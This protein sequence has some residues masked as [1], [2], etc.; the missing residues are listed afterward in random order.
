MLARS[1]K[2][3]GGRYDDHLVD[4][5]TGVVKAI[6]FCLLLIMYWAINSQLTNTF[7][8]QAERMD[9]RLG[10]VNIP[11]A[12]LNAFNTIGIIVLIPLVDKV[13]YPFFE[14]VRYPLT[15]LKRIGPGGPDVHGV[16]HVRV[17]AGPPVLPHRNQRDLRQRHGAENKKHPM[18]KE[19]IQAPCLSP[20]LEFAYHQA[21]VAMQGLLTGLFLASPGI[22]TWGAVGILAVV[23]RATRH[24]PWFSIEIN[25]SKMENLMFLLAGLMLLNLLVF[26]VVAHLYSYQD[27]RQFQLDV[28]PRGKPQG[29]LRTLGGT[30][31]RL[32][33]DYHTLGARKDVEDS[34]CLAVLKEGER[35]PLT[36]SGY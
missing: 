31:D 18:N 17:H 23:R 7:F 34:K 30:Y 20:A 21:P 14:R 32:D 15:F 1:K 22:G 33:G 12:A 27:P 25:E 4:G 19:Y 29:E 10:S 35:T 3:F 36:S 6:P 24:D 28:A 26:C 8:A 5:V 2:S 16:R 9:I 13:V 11:A